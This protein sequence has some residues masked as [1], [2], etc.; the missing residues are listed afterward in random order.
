MNPITPIP[1]INKGIIVYFPNIETIKYLVKLEI[2]YSQNNPLFDWVNCYN[3]EVK[4]WEQTTTKDDFGILFLYRTT[5]DLQP[6]F[7]TIKA[8][9]LS[10]QQSKTGEITVG[11]YQTTP[12]L[13][14]GV[15]YSMYPP[16]T[17]I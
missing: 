16:I 3:S 13:A 17:L 12:Y 4:I 9:M 11:L 14:I 15:P 5:V 8:T 1:Y 10:N 2:Y 6:G 7:Y